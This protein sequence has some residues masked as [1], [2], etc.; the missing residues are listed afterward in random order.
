MNELVKRNKGVNLKKN[1][2]NEKGSYHKKLKGR[3]KKMRN[4]N[5]IL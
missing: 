2:I 1:T 5:C 3:R 4:N